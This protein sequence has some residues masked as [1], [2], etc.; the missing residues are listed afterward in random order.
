MSHA[1]GTVDVRGV[2]EDERAT[3]SKMIRN[4]MMHAICRKPVHALDLDV[5]LLD[6]ALAYVVPRKLLVLMFDFLA[7]RAD[8]PRLALELPADSARDRAPILS[9]LRQR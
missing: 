4:A 9:A 2:A 1:H 5:H 7:H 6:H 3:I 8:Q